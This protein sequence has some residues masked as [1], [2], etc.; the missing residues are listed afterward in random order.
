MA[1]ENVS[2]KQE[3]TNSNEPIP[4]L[5]MEG[6]DSLSNL[7]WSKGFRV[8]ESIQFLDFTPLSYGILN[9]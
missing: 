9:Y 1:Y 3:N 8:Q 7:S 6:F 2:K 5:D 4:M